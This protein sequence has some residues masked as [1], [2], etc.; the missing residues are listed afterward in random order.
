MQIKSK[1]NLDIVAIQFGYMFN[2]F[3]QDA[4]K[5]NEINNNKIFYHEET[6]HAAFPVTSINRYIELFDKNKLSYAIVTQNKENNKIKSRSISISSD[7]NLLGVDF[8]QKTSNKKSQNS[9]KFINAIFEGYN[10]ITGEVFSE[11]SVWKHPEIIN[12]LKEYFNKKP[13]KNNQIYSIGSTLDLLF[14]EKGNI[15][16]NLNVLNKFKSSEI[17]KIYNELNKINNNYYSKYSINKI[18]VEKAKNLILTMYYN[19]KNDYFKNNKKITDHNIFKV[20]ETPNFNINQLSS[21]REFNSDI[22][23]FREE[24]KKN[25]R[26]LN[27]GMPN[28]EEEDKAILKLYQ[29]YKDIDYLS[30]YF[31]RTTKSIIIRLKNLGIKLL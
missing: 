8:I 20:E 10:P 21:K 22:K 19:K 18:N 28:H 5:I 26:M 17:K 24:N 29:E 1:Y 30:E 3:D 2:L 6:A 7:P 23:Q 4:I 15:K 13:L 27:H 14:D 25:G 12:L 9:N 31:Q 16:E 11:D